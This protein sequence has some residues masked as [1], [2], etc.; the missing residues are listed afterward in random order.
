VSQWIADSF[1]VLMVLSFWVALRFVPLIVRRTRSGEFDR[2]GLALGVSVFHLAAAYT[3][4]WFYLARLDRGVLSDFY[5]LHWSVLVA[6][7][8]MIAGC[9]IWMVTLDSKRRRLPLL[10]VPFG[11]AVTLALVLPP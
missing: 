6:R 1:V 10:F 8:G 7:V 5:S 9:L 11:G 4:M 3:D 2:A